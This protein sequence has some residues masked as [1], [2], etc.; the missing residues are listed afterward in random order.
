MSGHSQILSDGIEHGI[1]VIRI[2]RSNDGH[3]LL[4]PL[5]L[6]PFY[7]FLLDWGCWV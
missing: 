7:A 4:L 6:L 2:Q 5:A 1:L 3:R